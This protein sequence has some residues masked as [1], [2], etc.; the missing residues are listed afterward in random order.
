MDTAQLRNNLHQVIDQL[1]T[2]ALM[3][4]RAVIATLKKPPVPTDKRIGGQYRGQ[5]VIKEDF[6]RLPDD[7][8]ATFTND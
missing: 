4:L 1:D 7:F 6:D 8:M 5:F 3:Q 2:E